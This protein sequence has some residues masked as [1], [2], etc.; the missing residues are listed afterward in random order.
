[1]TNY[2]LIGLLI[3]HLILVPFAFFQFLYV[4]KLT[5]KIIL[6]ALLKAFF[7]FPVITWE[8]IKAASESWNELPDE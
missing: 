3:G 1:M 7:W 8:L 6:M 2:F 5:K 4:E